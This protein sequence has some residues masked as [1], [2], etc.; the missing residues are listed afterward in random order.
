VAQYVE[1][2]GGITPRRDGANPEKATSEEKEK[3]GADGLHHRSRR[4]PKST[5]WSLQEQE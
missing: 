4:E 2:P 5:I 1:T 3:K